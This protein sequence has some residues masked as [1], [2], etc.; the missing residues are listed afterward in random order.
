MKLVFTMIALFVLM[1]IVTPALTR[2]AY[3]VMIGGIVIG[4][5]MFYV[6]WF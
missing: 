1:G 2:R 4:I 3:S 5:V 6:A